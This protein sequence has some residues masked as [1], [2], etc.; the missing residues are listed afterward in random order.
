MNGHKVLILVENYP[1]PFDRRVWLEAK[2]LR[3]AG[4]QVSIIC[5]KGK[6]ATESFVEIDGIRIYRYTAWEAKKGALAF[7]FEFSRCWL[8]TFLL[9]IKVLFKDGFDVIHACNPPDT[10]WVIGAIYKIL[11]K[12]FIF[13]Q[14]DLNP[15]VYLSKF[16]DQDGDFAHRMLY[17]FE[18]RTYRTADVV[19]A[20][21]ESYRNT[22]ISRGGVDPDRVI[23]VRTGPDFERLHPVPAEPGLKQGADFLVAYL[24][25]MAP[26]DG[27][28]YLLQAAAHIVHER[29]RTNVRFVF[30]G[31]GSSLDDLK[32][33][34]G[35]LNLADRCTFTGRVSDADL[36]RWLA[37]ADVCASPDP[38]N[39]LNEVST[40][41]KTMEYMA[42]GKPV[43]SFALKE[44][45]ESAGEASLYAEPNRTDEFGDR[46]IELLD[47]PARRESMGEFGRTR[48][49]EKLAWNHSEPHLLKAYAKALDG[50]P[51]RRLRILMI[52]QKGVPA[53]YGGIERHVEEIG[54]RMVQR[55]HE[56]SVYCRPHYT[57]QRGKHRG[58]GMI[59]R[60]SLNTKHLDTLTHTLVCSID[61]LFRRVDVV[62][63]HAL[64]PSPFALLPR[65]R[66]IKTIVTVHGLDWEREKW[67]M[68]AAYILQ[69]CEYPAIHFPNATIVVSQT[70][71][72]YFAEKYRIRPRHIPNGTPEPVRRAPAEIR[73]YGIGEKDYILFVGRLTPEKGAHFLMEAFGRIDTPMKLV[74]AGGTSFTDDYVASLEAMKTD[75]VILTGYVYGDTLAELYTN[76][77]LVVLPSTM[78]GLSI[79]LLEAVSYG[80]CVL[81]SDI[82]ENVEV[83]NECAPRFRSRDVDHLETQLRHLLDN[84]AEVAEFE[85]MTRDRISRRFSWETI[86]DAIETTYLEVDARRYVA[87]AEAPIE[88]PVPA[89]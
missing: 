20:M 65:L 81:I 25:T 69:R 16:P 36:R 21:N 54:A 49:H 34:A 27:V 8:R 39:P 58:M 75:R 74:I 62:H 83:M 47:D 86:V 37:T 72:N 67:G 5:P 18:K 7:A 57:R 9:T 63:Y 15:E 76:A 22:A 53:T 71:E 43:V 56:V 35:T 44:T 24:G 32:A 59:V 60:P 12:R 19:I 48:V 23:V 66:G 46:I 40:M 2:T 31:S 80:K 29:G 88:S 41:N 77:H 52:G 3:A 64:G 45:I 17:W 6:G 79:A 50:V 70:L 14:H 84:P 26:Q 85:A 82:P 33:L 55:G 28:D 30:I 68:L 1:L 42:M 4:Y 61:A 87:R 73:Q 89:T 38:R 11:G 78:E 51:A 13:D 10:F